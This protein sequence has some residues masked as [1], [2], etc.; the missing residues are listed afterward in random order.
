MKQNIQGTL[1]GLYNNNTISIKDYNRI[2]HKNKVKCKYCDGILIGKKGQIKA[3]HFSHKNK[4]ICD[5]WIEN[6]SQW[7][8]EWQN[9]FPIK[10]QEIVINKEGVKHIADIQIENLIIEIQHSYINKENIKARE[11]F[12]ENMI[13]IVDGN[14]NKSKKGNLKGK[15]Y[16]I[17]NVNENLELYKSK[18]QWFRYTKKKTYINSSNKLYEV[19]KYLDNDYYLLKKVNINDIINYHKKISIE[20]FRK[21]YYDKI[22]INKYYLTTSTKIIYKSGYLLYTGNNI[23]I[24]KILE[25][26]NHYGKYCECGNLTIYYNNK[27]IECNNKSI[28]LSR[29]GH[30]IGNSYITLEELKKYYNEMIKLKLNKYILVNIIDIIKDIK[31]KRKEFN[32]IINKLNF[33]IKNNNLISFN[34]IKK[35]DYIINKNK[36]IFN[37]NKIPG[38]YINI[39]LLDLY[40]KIILYIKHQRQQLLCLIYN[41]IID[42]ENIN[43]NSIKNLVKNSTLFNNLQIKNTEQINLSKLINEIN[44]IINNR[45]KLLENIKYNINDDYIINNNKIREI[46]KLISNNLSLYDFKKIDK[47]YEGISLSKFIEIVEIYINEKRQKI[48]NKIGNNIADDKDLGLNILERIKDLVKEYN[49]IKKN[50]SINKLIDEINID[51]SYLNNRKKLL[52]ELNIVIFDDNINTNSEIE[53]FIVYIKINLDDDVIDKQI[54]ILDNIK[55]SKLIKKIYNYIKNERLNILK[56]FGNNIIDDNNYSLKE[57]NRIYN[58]KPI[59]Y[60]K[61]NSKLKDVIKDI[62]NNENNNKMK[63]IQEI[64]NLIQIKQPEFNIWILGSTYD[65]S[66]ELKNIDFKKIK[67]IKDIYINFF[68]KFNN[69]NFKQIL[70]KINE[71]ESNKLKQYFKKYNSSKFSFIEFVLELDKIY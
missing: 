62:I 35:L 19:Y 55:L 14:G 56:K 68:N 63:I 41:N 21:F 65:I 22:E 59:V 27:C 30:G 18:K 29:F 9:L 5:N 52:N 48:L 17:C 44:E 2:L 49:I 28:L 53:Q 36:E 69:S 4:E 20:K 7:H 6:K 64:K 39:E 58:E 66:Y 54:K 60:N 1:T 42:D 26:T 32:L 43:I 50:I 46:N 34:K 13:W 16:K 25:E 45:K 67:N 61:N 47:L 33:P 70:K 24:I 12:Y 37:I 38:I 40:E 71:N 23:K 11:N 8:I 51:I 10:N 31:E 57:L 15:I 3:H